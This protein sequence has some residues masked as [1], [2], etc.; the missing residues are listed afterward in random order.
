M[1]T[2]VRAGS[3]NAFVVVVSV[4]MTALLAGGCRKSSEEQRREAQKATAEAEEQASQVS[5]TT[6]TNAEIGASDG[7]RTEEGRTE[8]AEEAREA[9]ARALREHAEAITSA[10]NE[11]LEYRGKLQLALDGLDAKRRDAKKRGHVHVKAI[12]ARREVLKHDLD[13]L[14]R[15]TDTEWASLKS[16]IE[17]D[18]KDHAGEH[19]A[20]GEGK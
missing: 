14:D 13:A 2:I 6:I 16:K 12:D 19:A 9:R 4:V 3:S 7:P 20:E 1:A 11:Q 17:R 10:R 15:S 18:L 8:A 5:Q